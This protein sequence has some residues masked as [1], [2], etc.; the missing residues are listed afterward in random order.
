MISREE[1]FRAVRELLCNPIEQKPSVH[2]IVTA[3]LAVEREMLQEATGMHQAWSINTVSVS[4]VVDQ[5]E[6]TITANSGST[7]GKALFAYREV[8]DTDIMPVPFTDY[9]SEFNNQK[10]EF[11]IAPYGSGEWPYESGEKLAFYRN[12]NVSK[13]RI[14]PIPDEVREY[15]IVYASGVLDWTTFAWSDVPNFP[16]HASFRQV[17]EALKLIGKCAWSGYDFGQNQAYRRE[18]R[19]DLMFQFGTLKPEW[20]PFLRNVQHDEVI[21]DVGYWYS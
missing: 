4:S 20:M 10:H 19:E 7:F 12:L 11:W 17:R 15:Q 14:F 5:A 18:I 8:D 2:S 13:M 21:S 9:L 3:Q 1:D 16:E 6:Y